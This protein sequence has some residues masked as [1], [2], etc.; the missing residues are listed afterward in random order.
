LFVVASFLII[1]LI[2]PGN[3]VLINYVLIQQ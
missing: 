1:I 2:S 3:Q